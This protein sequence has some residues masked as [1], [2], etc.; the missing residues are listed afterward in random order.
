M[1]ET[2]K[3]ILQIVIEGATVIG[4]IIALAKTIIKAIKE[5]NWK[6]LLTLAMKLMAQ[7]E[8]SIE[9]GSDRK[10]FV[11]DQIKASSEYANYDISDTDLDK[12][13]ED[14]VELSKKVN[15]K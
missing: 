2:I 13:V 10:K 4:L 11:I 5:K 8:E 3:L 1:T 12:L 7:A 15:I 6:P 14:L 9:N